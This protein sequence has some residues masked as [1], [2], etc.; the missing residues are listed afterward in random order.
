[1]KSERSWAGIICGFVLFIVVCLSL[2]LHMK[3]AFRASGNP[4]LGLLFFLLPGAAAS[5][6]SPGQRVLRPLLGAMLAAPVCMV[7]MR[8]FFVTHRTFWQEMAWVLSA[9]FWCA[10]GA[11]CFLF[12]CSW[13]DTWRSHS[14]SK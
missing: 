13:L 7:T 1:M 4:E 5:C 14:S 12:I 6:L 3:G 9:V 10:L 11:L 2:L 8:L